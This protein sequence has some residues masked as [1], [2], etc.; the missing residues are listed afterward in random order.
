MHGL[1]KN[2]PFSHQA[3]L[4]WCKERQLD[5]QHA[6]FVLN[7]VGVCNRQCVRIAEKKLRDAAGQSF[8]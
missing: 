5:P 7:G 8:A 3:K 1:D 4:C 2:L 6:T